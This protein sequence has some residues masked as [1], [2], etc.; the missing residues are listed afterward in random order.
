M[1]SKAFNI[2]E[3]YEMFKGVT[4]VLVGFSGGADS[5]AL[6][7]FLYFFASDKGKKFSVEAVHVNHCLRGE[8]AVRD[9]NFVRSFCEKFGIKLHIK[10][11]DVK[12][13]AKKNKVGLEE[14]GRA[15]RYETFYSLIN[16]ESEKIATAH[17]LSDNCETFIF[18][19]M[20]GA[21]LKDL[22][23]IPPTRDRIVRPLINVTREEIEKYCLD[24]GIDYIHDST[25]FERDYTRNKIRLDVIPVLKKINPDFEKSVLRTVETISEDEKYLDKKSS[26]ILESVRLKD[27][28]DSK[29]IKKLPFCLKSRLA[30]KI[31][32]ESSEKLPEKKYVDLIC[33]IMDNGGAV[34]LSNTIDLICKN[35]VLKICKKNEK[36]SVEKVKWE[37]PLKDFNNLTEIETNII[38]KVIPFSEYSNTDIKINKKNVFDLDKLPPNCFIRNRRSGDRFTFPFRKVTKSVKKL[39]N[40]LKIAENLRHK[41]AMI[42]CGNEVIWIDGVGTSAKYLI[43]ENTEKIAIIYKERIR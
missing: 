32:K 33:K 19:L 37:Y 25:N 3:K 7:H 38:I 9:E 10:R 28:Y 27:G 23:G 16:S 17:T 22:C 26:E 31:I 36:K 41:T 30:V 6:L 39:M 21:A 15:A 8:E 34:T 24:N 14:A 12:S 29:K 40:E 13:I 1:I 4:K 2:I 20:R 42:A 35:D 11:I 18:N 43:D 5:S